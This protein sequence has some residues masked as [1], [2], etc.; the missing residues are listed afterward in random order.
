MKGGA[1]APP[2]V[3]LALAC[4]VGFLGPVL[5]VWGL[6]LGAGVLQL[7]LPWWR[8]SLKLA[9]MIYKWGFGRGRYQSCWFPSPAATCQ[10]AVRMPQ[11]PE[12]AVAPP[13][14]QTS[15]SWPPQQH[16]GHALISL[17]SMTSSHLMLVDNPPATWTSRCPS[18][19]DCNPL[20]L[21]SSAAQQQQH[22][23]WIRTAPISLVSLTSSRLSRR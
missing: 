19:R 9:C 23:V 17:V 6:G 10:V 12:Q 16:K 4:T 15:G 11:C 7:V 3:H 8:L 18:A 14:A 22:G 13:G 20:R 1:H 5:R 21:N 2:G